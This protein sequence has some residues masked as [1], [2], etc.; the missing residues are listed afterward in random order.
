MADLTPQGFP[1]IE[2]HR[3][4]EKS[5]V[6]VR[7]VLIA[8][9]WLVAIAIA[10][11]LALWGLLTLLDATPNRA[12]ASLSPLAR[13]P[14]EPPPPRL[15]AYP[16]LDLAEFR[17]RESAELNAYRWQDR[18]SGRTQIPIERAE[19]LFLDEAAAAAR[20]ARPAAAAAPKAPEPRRH[21]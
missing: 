8:A 12:A 5:D 2:S 13:L 20:A 10:I 3:R 7:T 19:A 1:S 16:P 11:H 6:R 9:A 21:P 4:H 15:Q 14:Q 18:R 17:T